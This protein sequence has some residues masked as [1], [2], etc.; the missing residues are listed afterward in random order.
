VSFNKEQRIVI[1]GHSVSPQIR[2]T[3]AYLRRKGLRVTCVEFNYFTTSMGEELLSTE[4]VVGHEPVATQVSSSASINS[5]T[6]EKF[7]SLAG[8]CS[9]LFQALFKMAREHGFS[10]HWGTKGFSMGIVVDGN[11]V[12]FLYGYPPDSMV[13]DYCSIYTEFRMLNEKVQGAAEL[14][15]ETRAAL[16][17]TGLWQRGGNELKVVMSKPL[18]DT[19]IAEVETLMLRLA[20]EIQRRGLISQSVADEDGG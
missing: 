17:A 16:T 11:R 14:A 15:A 13:K 9:P 6:E 8:G 12:V 2:E 7:L 5:M 18:T 19:Q 1:V 10:I 4:I 3:S 20:G